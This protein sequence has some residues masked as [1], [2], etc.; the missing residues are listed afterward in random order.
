MR[1]RRLRAKRTGVARRRPTI[2]LRARRRGQRT[3]YASKVTAMNA[4]HRDPRTRRTRRTPGAERLE[5]RTVLSGG[6]ANYVLSGT[7]WPNPAHITYSIAPDGVNWGAGNNNLNA[8]FDAQFGN[9]AWQRALARALA[10][11][12]A[13]AN[14][15]IVPMGESGAWPLW[16]TGQT[17]G[18]PRFGDIRF[19]GTNFN[20]NQMLAQSYSPP[21]PGATESVYGDVEMNTAMP[22][23]IGA[24][25][26]IYSVM[27]H[28]TGLALGLS[29]P[30]PGGADVVMN[31]VYGGVRT[32]LMPGDIA[33]I[34]AIYGPRTPDAYQSRGQGT[35]PDTAVDLS[36]AFY[37]SL[38]AT[39]GNLSLPALGAPEYFTFV[40]PP[41]S[42]G[43]VSVTASSAGISLLSPAV[44]VYSGTGQLLATQANPGAWSDAVTVQVSGL[45][46]NQ[47]YY[48][49]V[50]GATADAFS[51]GAYQLQVALTG[52]SLPVSHTATSNVAPVVAIYQEVL[53]RQPTAA[54]E[55]AWLQRLQ[56][57]AS[58]QQLTV[59]LYQSSAHQA[60][61][62][63]SLFETY[64]GR[65]ADPAALAAF[66]GWLNAGAGPDDIALAL[67]DS[68][69]FS[70]DYPANSAF[71]GAVYQ[72]AL[73]RPL[74]PA[75]AALFAQWLSLGATRAQVAQA[76]VGSV[77][78]RAR[79]I[80]VAYQTVLGRPAD[81]AGQ[82][83]FLALLQTGHS[84]FDAME[85]AL[86]LSDENLRR[87]GY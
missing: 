35:N 52:G 76:V 78:Y 55:S 20:N 59:A 32:G 68:P 11:W 22:W 8:T 85:L 72:D 66:T 24:G 69:E 75:G 26:D 62:I 37:G 45:A 58:P 13:V 21:T 5:E 25:Y 60:F 79:Q 41:N 3:A 2:A 27:L 84:A 47:R 4:R 10:T 9:G 81:P 28:E 31:T 12:E 53:G 49:E 14:I 57:G 33:G 42:G 54:E 63:N 56:S 86:L 77:E 67:I 40:D 6:G 74:D 82:Q 39:L 64:L 15:E 44:S 65:P 43:T 23:Q 51:V 38:Q 19:G 83:H 73:G 46:A 80:T 18:D 87:V 1:S 29:E 17:Q 34:Q 16:S 70:T 7:Q 50:A 71:L 36:P 48:I 30:P 61:E